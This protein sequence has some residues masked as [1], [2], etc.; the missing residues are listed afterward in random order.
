MPSVRTI[1]LPWLLSSLSL[2]VAPLQHAAAPAAAAVKLPTE[3]RWSVAIAA[4]PVA[5]PIIAGD[6]VFVALQ[7]G[8]VAAHRLADGSE[9]WRTEILAEQ[10]LALDQDRLIVASGEAIQALAADSGKLLWRT[11]AGTLSAPPLA[12]DGWVIAAT[13]GAL[14]AYRGQDGSK[15]WGREA[16]PARVPPTIEGN[17]LYVPLDDGRLLALDLRTG[18][19]RWERRLPV[20]THTGSGSTGV[21]EVLAYPDRVFVGASDGRFYSLKAEDGSLAWRFRVGAVVRGRPVGE[22]NRIFITTMNN[23]VSAYNRTT[24]ALLW[25]PT[26]PFRPAGPVML[27]GVVMVPGTASEVRSFDTAGNPGG[28]IKLEESV[29]M[30]PAFAES[31]GGA[32]MAAVSGSLNGQWKLLLMEQPRGVAVVPLTVMPGETVPVDLPAAKS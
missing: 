10:P 23:V 32:V 27:G 22:G 9:E 2:A 21:S 28:Q 4:R 15:V 19:T 14:A 31:A 12:Q 29:V 25:H 3:P 30:A 5:S 1:L 8:I 26:L 16:G 6:R 7:T 18:A 13:E 24:G 20:T 11:P 17:N